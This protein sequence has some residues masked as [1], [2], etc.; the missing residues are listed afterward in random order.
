MIVSIFCLLY[1]L[2]PVVGETWYWWWHIPSL[3]CLIDDINHLSVVLYASNNTW[4]EFISQQGE[5]IQFGLPI[6]TEIW[7]KNNPNVLVLCAN[8]SAYQE[9]EPKVL[10]VLIRLWLHKVC[11][12]IVYVVVSESILLPTVVQTWIMNRTFIPPR[13][14]HLGIREQLHLGTRLSHMSV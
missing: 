1:N 10:T 2:F 6:W 12:S 3:C 5:H 4:E 11:V 8:M 14:N 9:E 13:H 7:Y